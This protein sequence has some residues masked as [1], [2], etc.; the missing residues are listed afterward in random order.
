MQLKPQHPVFK[1]AS[2]HRADIWD[3]KSNFSLNFQAA[4]WL[5]FCRL[6]QTF[7]HA[8]TAHFQ[9]EDP[10]FK[11]LYNHGKQMLAAPASNDDA[12]MTEFKEKIR[13][14]LKNCNKPTN[15]FDLNLE[16]CRRW[17]G[18][19]VEEI[20]KALSQTINLA[21]CLRRQQTAVGGVQ[22]CHKLNE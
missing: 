1:S 15:N 16:N 10:V 21:K 6:R 19:N 11:F 9:L 12:T 2:N 4:L 17:C 20:L 8:P 18:E 5:F 14:C 22:R 13:E 7:R 3:D